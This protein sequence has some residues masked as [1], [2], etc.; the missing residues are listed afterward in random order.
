M[1]VAVAPIGDEDDDA[2]S[3]FDRK[4]ANRP[5]SKTEHVGL[6]W[7]DI[8]NLLNRQWCARNM[9]YHQ[10]LMVHVVRDDL[11]NLKVAAGGRLTG[12]KRTRDEILTELPDEELNA[13]CEAAER[14]TSWVDQERDSE[15]SEEQAHYEHDEEEDVEYAE[16]SDAEIEFLEK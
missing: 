12:E 7:V 1:H 14:G 8:N 3:L 16:E 15:E 13:M 10:R 2:H 9:H 6:E 5:G 11:S 4:K